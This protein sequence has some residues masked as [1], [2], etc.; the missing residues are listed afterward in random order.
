MAAEIVDFELCLA[1]KMS[2]RE[3]K[4]RTPPYV[5]RVW[6]DLLNTKR[7]IESDKA[8]QARRQ[9]GRGEFG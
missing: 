9:Q 7:R 6:T 2:W 4:E 3:W 8:E 1:F 5:Q